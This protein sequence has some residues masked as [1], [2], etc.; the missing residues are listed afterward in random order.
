MPTRTVYEHALA[1]TVTARR[2]FSFTS[3]LTP[4]ATMQDLPTPLGNR[5]GVEINE[6]TIYSTMHVVDTEFRRH[7]R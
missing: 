2:S 4:E 1:S 7:R 3:R 5:L 6:K